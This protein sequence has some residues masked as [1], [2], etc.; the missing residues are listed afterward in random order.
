MIQLLVF[1]HKERRFAFRI[2]PHYKRG[3]IIEVYEEL[4]GIDKVDRKSHL[5]V[6]RVKG[7]S[8][9]E[10]VKYRKKRVHIR[11]LPRD[12]R[13]ELRRTGKANIKSDVFYQ[14]I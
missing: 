1:H 4:A 9:E 13:K 5:R 2:H 12:V 8:Y 11:K 10:G 7:I 3:G 6:I 14:A